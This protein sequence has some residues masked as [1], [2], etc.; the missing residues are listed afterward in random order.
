M[1]EVIFDNLTVNLISKLMSN[2]GIETTNPESGRIS[3]YA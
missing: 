1:S 3:N 2:V